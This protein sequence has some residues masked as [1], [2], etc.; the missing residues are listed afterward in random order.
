MDPVAEGEA[1]PPSTANLA[2]V[3][4]TA[5]KREEKVQDV[6]LPITV[7]KGD[8]VVERNVNT[9]NDVERLAPN[10]AAQSS[11]GRSSRP[12]WF[13]RGI[14]SNDPSVNLESPL[15]IYADE[16]FTAYVP[17]QS[18]PLFDLERVEVLKG[19]QGTLWGKNTT[20]GAIHFVSRKPAFD[21]SGYF[22][23][24]VGNYGAK[25][26][27]GGFGGA[28][29][30]ERVA[31]RA[32]FYYEEQDGWAKN[33]INNQNEPQLKDFATRLQLLA[34]PADNVEFLLIGRLRALNGGLAPVYQAGAL[35]DGTI[36]Q[37][38][39]APSTYTPVYGREP[40]IGD[41][42]FRTRSGYDLET[43]GV[44]GKLDVHLGAYTLTSISAVDWAGVDH[45]TGAYLP[46]PTF[47]VTGTHASV[48][49]RQVSQELRLTSP[50]ADRF[51][52]IAGFHYFN[53]HL[54]ADEARGTLGPVAARKN[55]IDNRL[56]QDDISYAG[57]A[58]AKLSITQ[59]L[60]LTLGVRQTYEKK[61]VAAQRLS[62]NGA[63]LTFLNTADW[64]LSGSVGSALSNIDINAEED[65]SET[66]YDVTP[67]LRLGE[68]VLA[69]FRVA[70][71]FRSGGFNPSIIPEANGNPA[72]LPKANPEILHDFEL[73]L[74]TTW[75]GGKLLANGAL[76][77]YR[78]SDAQLN[79]QQPNP[80]GIPNANTSTLQN[81]AG[82][83]IKGAELEIEA[84]PIAS[85]YLRAGLGLLRSEYTNFLTF[86]GATPVDASGNEFYRTPRTSL[87]VAGA[88]TLALG[89][90][91]ALVLETD[92]SYRSHVFH[93]AVTQN[94]PVQE[95]PGY[96]LGNLA[97]RYVTP[98]LKLV[99]QAFVK[100]VTDESYKVL[101]QVVNLG[102]NPTSLGLPRT[103]GLQL[104]GRF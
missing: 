55:Y 23:V 51:N 92:W 54:F 50:K 77:Y 87:V 29:L 30:G 17:A 33:L 53:W 1:K 103:Y 74:K 25:T 80:A 100:N 96:A 52:W 61:T 82:G 41:P 36:R 81:A 46:D 8:E 64:W 69:F 99:L 71:G 58:N 62:A 57:F 4:V 7:V 13:L 89:T 20:G 15:G 70:K 102:A 10:L 104:I 60:G 16:V 38:M 21:P 39:G 26:G 34:N 72:Y 63:G 40:Q 83:V 90:A 31:G 12:R 24:G 3:V 2:D 65:W 11:G 9:S 73:G 6:P 97:L 28:L 32:S 75:L 85:L 59:A 19:P 101:S 93:N 91:G 76:F 14:G 94:D 98:S 43:S 68:N 45:A 86:Q 48:K 42:F 84:L 37:Y 44:T 47:D 88:Y 5:K 67:E 79:V 35:P 49:S 22:K 78:L 27:E 18:F 95:T 56:R 66:T